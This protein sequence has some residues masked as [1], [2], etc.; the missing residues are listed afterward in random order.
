MSLS[1]SL[2]AGA[3]AFALLP[4]AGCGEAKPS[5][6]TSSSAPT[7]SVSATTVT[8]SSQPGHAPSS[9]SPTSTTPAPA[10]VTVP[11]YWIGEA[12]PSTFLYREF[13]KL[14]DARGKVRTALLGMMSLQPTDP[15]LMTFWSEP[16]K[17]EVTQK[18][19][20]ITVNLAKDAF[21]N[22]N[23]G[24]ANAALSLQQ[25]VY[26]AT[27]AAQT[28]GSVTILVEGRSAE[29]WGVVSVGT[30]MKRDVSARAPIW[31]ETP[32]EGAVVPAGKVT[33][34][35]W[36][37][38]FEGHVSL[39]ITNADGKVVVETY[40]LGAMGEFKEFSRVVT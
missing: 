25:L 17:L 21:A 23:V 29:V 38:V 7:P 22:T 19:D 12:A 20:D 4:L 10:L 16:S 27:A 37:N 8:P 3:V 11:L 5:A 31:L 26:T 18:G 34:K 9:A 35:G 24:S 30:P 2:L 15:D 1:K 32:V 13:R 33:I 40:A 39:E 28:S 36:A 6:T 14:P